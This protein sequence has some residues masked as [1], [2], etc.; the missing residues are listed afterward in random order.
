MDDR[1]VGRFFFLLLILLPK[2]ATYGLPG[3]NVREGEMVKGAEKLLL[4]WYSH[5]LV[6]CSLS[7]ASV[8]C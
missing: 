7:L 3:L 2:L 5:M 1:D 8:Q 6:L 4:G